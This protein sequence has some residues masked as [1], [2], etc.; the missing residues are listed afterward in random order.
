M[1]A[2]EVNEQAIFR[3]LVFALAVGTPMPA[4]AENNSLAKIIQFD[5]PQQ[6][7]DLSL[8]E[9]AEQADIT[10]IFPFDDAAK[11]VT[12]KLAGRYSIEDAV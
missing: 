9:F 12:N 3:L 10:L 7:A 6:R 1:L 2:A 4:W 8:T 5:I 11:I